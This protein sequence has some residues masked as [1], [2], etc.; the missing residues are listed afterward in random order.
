MPNSID[1]I[2]GHIKVIREEANNVKDCFTKFSFQSIA[3]YSVVIIAVIRYQDKIP[4]ITF[5][6][7]LSSMFML[8]VSRIGTYKYTTANRNYGFELYLRRALVLEGVQLMS[9]EDALRAWRIV[10][11]TVFHSLYE[12]K[13]FFKKF[14]P[15]KKKKNK[16]W[17]NVNSLI[18]NK[19]NYYAGGYLRTMVKLHKWLAIFGL[20]PFLF[21]PI[22]HLKVVNYSIIFNEVTPLDWILIISGFF[23]F[24]YILFWYNTRY[25][26][27]DLLESGILSIFSSAIM[28][29]AV[30]V[31]H[32]IAINENDKSVVSYTKKISQLA[33]EISKRPD[34]IPAWLRLKVM[35]TNLGRIN[36]ETFAT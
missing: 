36:L 23:Y 29:Q 25:R 27:L 6:L 7:L 21:P 33:V 26:V 17:Y 13:G 12:T 15:K 3:F 9:W 14:R 11:P 5:A 10:Q 20:I 4:I 22:D 32:Y 16:V 30:G 28:W 18:D 2:L 31:C 34:S 35:K 24:L 1:T 8:V 19:T